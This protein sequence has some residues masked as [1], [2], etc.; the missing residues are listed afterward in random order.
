MPSMT[1][2]QGA[3]SR[4]GGFVVLL[5]LCW[6]SLN[7]AE[8]RFALSHSMTAVGSATPPSALA[9]PLPPASFE[10]AP[11]PAVPLPPSLPPPVPGSTESDRSHSA[12]QSLFTGML[13]SVD[14]IAAQL[15]K[16]PPSTYTHGGS[17]MG[18]ATEVEDALPRGGEGG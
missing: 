10:T 11:L 3:S 6:S 18:E 16:A 1:K 15:F 7:L 2:M 9:G 12:N 8:I 17:R 14:G 4:A 13:H 5:P